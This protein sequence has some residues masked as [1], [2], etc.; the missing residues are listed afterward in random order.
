MSFDKGSFF[1]ST[2]EM[3]T[4]IKINTYETNTLLIPCRS[5]LRS[6][7]C[8]II[9]KSFVLHIF[10]IRS[11]FIKIHHHFKTKSSQLMI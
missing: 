8:F 6:H 9:E 4:R 11:K 5:V 10:N 1:V 7:L 2:K 3:E